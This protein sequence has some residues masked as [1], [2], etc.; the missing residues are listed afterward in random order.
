M[1]KKAIFLFN[2]KDLHKD[3]DVLL[4]SDTCRNMTFS[5]ELSEETL[6]CVFMAKYS[7]TEFRINI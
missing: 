3:Y 2:A 6:F 1:A 4:Q 5:E 7:I